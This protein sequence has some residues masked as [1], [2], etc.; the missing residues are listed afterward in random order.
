MKDETQV[1]CASSEIEHSHREEGQLVKLEVELF[2]CDQGN[3][4]CHSCGVGL[5]A[6]VYDFDIEV[7]KRVDN[8]LEFAFCIQRECCE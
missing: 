3:F 7:S 6:E 4:A 2:T 8:L 1:P 5:M